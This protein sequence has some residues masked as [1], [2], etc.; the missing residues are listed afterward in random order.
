M[1]YVYDKNNSKVENGMSFLQK[2]CEGLRTTV[3]CSERTEWVPGSKTIIQEELSPQIEI[4]E[5]IVNKIIQKEEEAIIDCQLYEKPVDNIEVKVEGDTFIIKDKTTGAEFARGNV[6]N[7]KG[8][9]NVMYEMQ[10]K[11]L[12][13]QAEVQPQEKKFSL[14]DSNDEAPF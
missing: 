1:K 2:Y 13:P 8:Y 5:E 6:E 7:V 12:T 4:L 9:L 3:D 14:P 10:Q 11:N